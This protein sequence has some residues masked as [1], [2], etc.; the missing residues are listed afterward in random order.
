LFQTVGSEYDSFVWLRF[1]VVVALGWL[2]RLEGRDLGR[3]EP[4]TMPERQPAGPE[5]RLGSTRRLKLAV[6]GALFAAS[7]LAAAQAVSPSVV[8][9]G[10]GLTCAFAAVIGL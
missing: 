10:D 9:C 8:G 7:L 4:P 6:L 5:R 2:A 1:I 3:W